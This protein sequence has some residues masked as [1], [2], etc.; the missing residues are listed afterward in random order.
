[1]GELTGELLKNALGEVGE[2]EATDP[3]WD[4]EQVGTPIHAQC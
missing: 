4:F 1:M 2:E 3:E